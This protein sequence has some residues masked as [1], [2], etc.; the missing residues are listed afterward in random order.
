VRAFFRPAD[1]EDVVTVAS[2]HPGVCRPRGFRRALIATAGM[3]SWL[4]AFA[5][6][7]FADCGDAIEGERVA[8]HC[9]DVVVADVRLQPGDPVVID[10]CPADG[11]LVRVPAQ[12]RSVV[13]D[14]NGQEIRGSGV[15]TGIRI[16]SGG[17][18]G[19]EIVGGVG[20]VAGVVSGFGEGI[21]STRPDDLRLLTNVVVRDSR[22]TGVVLRG[23]RAAL[24]SVRVEGNGGDGLRTSGRSV[25]LI[26]VE[27]E[28]NGE[29]GLRDRSRAGERDVTSQRNRVS[30]A[31]RGRGTQ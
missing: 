30:D 5:V 26:G 1:K 9:G 14:L 12:S 11:L 23:N 3:A 6:P 27:A 28:D 19:A 15:G 10:R 17:S 24:E 7:A 22:D 21:R 2:V 4:V 18:E 20:G 31:G 16:L 13:V 8:C 29:R 25:D